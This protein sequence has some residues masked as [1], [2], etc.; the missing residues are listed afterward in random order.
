MEEITPLSTIKLRN[1][2]RNLRTVEDYIELTRF[3][4]LLNTQYNWSARHNT[5]V[6]HGLFW[7]K[8]LKVSPTGDNKGIA[9]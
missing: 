2:I 8:N 5:N 3:F 6:L 4:N 7:E 1:K 9:P